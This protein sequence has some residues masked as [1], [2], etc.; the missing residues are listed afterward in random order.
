[1]YMEN[2]STKAWL[3]A[4]DMG[5]GHGRAAYALKDLAFGGKIINANHYDG[6]PEKDRET[7]KKA[8]GWYEFIS[9][10]KKFPVIGKLSFF[11]FEQLALKIPDFDLKKNMSGPNLQLRYI[12]HLINKNGWGRDLV[13][14]LSSGLDGQCLPMITT[15]P[16]PAFMAEILNYPGEIFCIICD[17]D[18]A[19][20]WVSVKAKESRIKYLAASQR[21]VERLKLYGVRPENIFLTGFP[22]SKELIRDENLKHDFESR[23]LNLDPRSSQKSVRPLTITFAV[24][25]AGAQKDIG[26]EIV[27]KLAA[28]I[29]SSVVKIILV[30]GTRLDVKEYFEQKLPEFNLKEGVE[31]VF[32]EKIEDYFEK[33]NAA[34]RKSDI[35]WT[36]PSELSFYSVLGLP[37]IIAPPIGFHEKQNKLWLLEQGSGISQG[38]PKD[39]NQWLFALLEQGYFAKLAVNGFTKG[40]KLGTFNIEQVI[41]RCCGS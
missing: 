16:I 5:Y 9:R 37:I 8:R 3:V 14:R 41:S 40:E 4:V 30:A 15:F 6:I 25:G 19:R 20:L 18:I 13:F 32:E 1:M 11:I 27:E 31:I 38:N 21:S 36:K 23:M 10:F 26:V 33:F 2:L 29:K 12:F 17:T 7:W 22:L 34:I 39:V 24:G 28:K 35:L